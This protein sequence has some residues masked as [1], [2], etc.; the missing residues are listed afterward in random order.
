MSNPDGSA[1]VEPA[2]R[3]C[4]GLLA[5]AGKRA[6]SM[7]C[8]VLYCYLLASTKRE[9]E[10]EGCRPAR[11][12]ASRGSHNNIAPFRPRSTATHK[13][14]SRASSSRA[15]EA[16]HSPLSSPHPRRRLRRRI[17]QLGQMA[18]GGKLVRSKTV[19]T[20]VGVW[21]L[22]LPLGGGGGGGGGSGM[23]GRR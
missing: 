7:H 13:L 5:L 1:D 20:L 8:L 3:K 16:G 4:R 12:L 10:N 19:A 23:H 9:N 17:P 15:A 2:P 18:V 22:L 14:S 6:V 21:T 11:L